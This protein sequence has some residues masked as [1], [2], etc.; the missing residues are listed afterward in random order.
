MNNED[1]KTTL[2]LVV[3]SFD[4][5]MKSVYYLAVEAQDMLSVINA[6][7]EAKDEKAS[8]EHEEANQTPNTQVSQNSEV[9]AV[10]VEKKMTKEEVRVVL[11]RVA[12]AGYRQEVKNLLAKYNATNL[13]DVNEKDY[14]AL[15]AEAEGLING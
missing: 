12:K 11:S 14:V 3:E 2:K 1:F 9:G 8:N 15:V 10:Q 13:R 7:M 4:V 5:F 6:S